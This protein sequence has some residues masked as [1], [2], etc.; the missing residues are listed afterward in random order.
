MPTT[1]R[2]AI[3]VAVAVQLIAMCQILL[4][5]ASGVY[6]LKGVRTQYLEERGEVLVEQLLRVVR[7]WCYVYSA[8]Y[9]RKPA[10]HQGEIIR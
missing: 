8:N 9:N 10:L 5:I 7:Q 4:A 3:A 1:T 2:Q 6:I